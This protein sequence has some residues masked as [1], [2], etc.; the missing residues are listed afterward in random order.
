[1]TGHGDM[2]VQARLALKKLTL[3][4]DIGQKDGIFPVLE[5]FLG[6]LSGA[7]G[8]WDRALTYYHELVG[9]LLE[10]SFQTP[11]PPVGSLWQDYLLDSLLLLD[12]PFTRQAAQRDWE[13]LPEPVIQAAARD[14]LHLQCLY[15]LDAA[16]LRQ[17]MEAASFAAG[18]GAEG[19]DFSLWE[20]GGQSS[21]GDAGFAFQLKQ[22]FQSGVA[23]DKLL[24]PLVFY[25]HTVGTGAFSYCYAFRFQVNEAGC[26]LKPVLEPDPI[27]LA[28]LIGYENQRQQVV[29]NTEQFVRGF[30]ANNLLLYGDRGTGKSSTIKALVHEYGPRGLRVVEMAKQDLNRLPEL[31]DMIRYRP[32]RFIIFIDDLSFE[33]GEVDY[34][35]LKAVLEGS[36]EARPGNVLIYATSNRRHL[37]RERFSDREFTGDGEVRAQDTLQEKLSLAD[38]FAMTITFTSPDQ[39]QYLAIVAGL[40]EQAGLGMEPE[41]LREAALKWALWHNGFSGRTARQF[42]DDLRGKLGMEE[43]NH[44]R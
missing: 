10:H 27:R 41:Q 22:S 18:G 19:W 8:A 39:E 43:K 5:Q 17:A 13:G 21:S 40:A 32:H 6:E 14:L 25:Y 3:L 2:L 24:Q 42:I 34:K 11:F 9:R 12:N 20:P 36:L 4:R 33:E 23:W 26:R 1:M 29:R 15:N 38:R 16:V 37:I 30:P 31:L 44:R 28:N 35:F 7:Q